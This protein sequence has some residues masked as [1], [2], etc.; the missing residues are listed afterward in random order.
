MSAT[1]PCFEVC[2]LTMNQRQVGSDF[3]MVI[4]SQALH[5]IVAGVAIGQYARP[6]KDV[7][8]HEGVECSPRSIWNFSKT[9]SAYRRAL[10]LALSNLIRS[11][12]TPTATRPVSPASCA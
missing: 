3:R 10:L 2:E 1:K 5:A 11:G 12:R 6:D 7:L 8:L 9:Y 4:V